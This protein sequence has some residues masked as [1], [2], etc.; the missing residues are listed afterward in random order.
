MCRRRYL[1]MSECEA[2]AAIALPGIV[3][4]LKQAPAAADFP[5]G[6][7]YPS[8]ITLEVTPCKLAAAISP[9]PPPRPNRQPPPAPAPPRCGRWA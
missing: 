4:F 7:L 8:H 1:S 2:V 9:W 3:A 6:F 5:A